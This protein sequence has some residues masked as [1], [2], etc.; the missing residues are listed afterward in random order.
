V[1]SLYVLLGSGQLM[2]F[3]NINMPEVRAAVDAGDMARMKKAW[4]GMAWPLY[5]WIRWIRC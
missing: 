1:E 2:R 5:K 4:R 3:G